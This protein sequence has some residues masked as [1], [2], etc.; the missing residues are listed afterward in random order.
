[1]EQIAAPEK[2]LGVVMLGKCNLEVRLF[3]IPSPGYGQVRMKVKAS[4]LCGSD[5]N[6]IYRKES[7]KDGPGKYCGVVAGH[8]PCGEIDQLGDGCDGFEVGD[9]CIVYH[10]NGC[11]VCQ[12]CRMGWH[13][14]CT[15]TKRKAYGYQRDGG[16]S[17]YI[18]A[19]I[20]NLVKMPK[21]LTFVDGAMVACGV[22]TAYAACLRAQV[23][24]RDRVLIT[25]LGPVGL[26]I[27]LIARASGAE[28]Y[29]VE[30]MSERRQQAIAHNITLIE[31]NTEAAMKATD[32][33]GFEVCFDASG[34]SQARHFCLEAARRWG[35]V[36]YVGEGG[37]VTFSPSPMLLHKQI[38]L[39]GSWV[40]S[41]AQ[42]E[43][44]VELLAR[45]QLHPEILVT[46]KY[47]LK[48]AAT[49]YELFNT[50][51]TGKVAFIWD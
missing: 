40:C 14:S 8:E 4:T 3:D 17:D 36:V 47:R 30:L 50:G 38:T 34:N 22:G 44:L 10:I 13:I 41:M 5:L 26:C 51:K 35:R 19:D 15:G 11:G 46:H 31:S 25:G 43:D 29:G 45:W 24:G 21:F 9:R 28:V 23:S 37:N 20:Q 2:R 49:A 39:H 12:D 16:H 6:L 32:G 1:M 18:I 7:W 48:D 42:M 33:K 27:A